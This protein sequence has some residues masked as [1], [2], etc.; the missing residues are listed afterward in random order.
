MEERY[1]IINSITADEEEICVGAT[2]N[3]RWAWDVSDGYSGV[4]ARTMV[5]V[6]LKDNGPGYVVSESVSFF[7]HR[8]DPLRAIAYN[9]IS[10]LFDIAWDI[11]EQKFS[12]KEA[13]KAYFGFEIKR[14]DG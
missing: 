10:G 6:T 12:E 2:D 14:H 11:R 13:R 3:E 5:W 1:L 4:D 9:G 7:C 8:E